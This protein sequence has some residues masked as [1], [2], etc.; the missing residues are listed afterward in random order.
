LGAINGL[1][2]EAFIAQKLV[3]HL[4]QGAV[5]MMDNCSIHKHNPELEALVAAAGARIIYLPPDSP[6][7]LP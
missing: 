4:W 1:T 6:D 3:P 2:F 5:V 7:F